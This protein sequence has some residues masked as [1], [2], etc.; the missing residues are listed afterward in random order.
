MPFS[1]ELARENICNICGIFILKEFFAVYLRLK[2][3]QTPCI[4]LGKI[5]SLYIALG[6]GLQGSRVAVCKL[7][8][9]AQILPTA[10]VCAPTQELRMDFPSHLLRG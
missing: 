1:L 5:L 7:C 8:P 2:V 3:N 9:G 6:D 10:P 4:L